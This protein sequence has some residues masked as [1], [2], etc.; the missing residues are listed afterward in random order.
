MSVRRLSPPEAPGR[1]TI[2]LP[3]GARIENFGVLAHDCSGERV[4]W[5]EWDGS[6]R[7]ETCGWIGRADL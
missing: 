2:L 3:A 7:C 4:V 5:V 6:A 1:G